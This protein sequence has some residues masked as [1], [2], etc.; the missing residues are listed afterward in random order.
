MRLVSL[1]LLDFRNHE[2][3]EIEPG[4]GVN[5]FLGPNGSGKSNLAEAISCLSLGRGWRT[6]E[7][8]PLIRKG[9]DSAYVHARVEK[10]GLPHDVDI[11]F[12][13]KGRR[14][15]IDGHS[16]KRL[17]ELA[18]LV[19]VLTYAPGDVDFFRGPPSVRRSHLDMVLAKDSE[20]Y[21]NL[22]RTAKSLL[23]ERN[24]LLKAEKV[25]MT[26]LEVITSRLVEASVRIEAARKAYLGEIEP[27]LGSVLSELR[28][29]KTSVRIVHKPF[30]KGENPRKEALEAYERVLRVDLER[31]TT[32]VGIH[33]EDYS[34]EV[35]GTD[36]GSFGSQGENR[37]ASLAYKL[38]LAFREG[39]GEK[40]IVILDD[41]WSELDETRGNNLRSLVGRLG[42][43]FV[44]ATSF[45]YEG[46]TR[47]DI[48]GLVKKA[49]EEC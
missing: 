32:T 42:Q 25:D 37:L 30:L 33:R 21:M 6:N 29:E 45:D 12:T 40:P 39:A 22:A 4:P 15:E 13:Q 1:S 14:I 48:G 35:D 31:K 26:A 10:G 3:T 5:L 7:L 8:A 2:R 24:A 38:S 16:V 47:F 46:A 9:C 17:S 27:V 41:A 43:C 44:T 28:G 11:A 36:V 49:K 23:E 18:R 20:A 34:L 19:N